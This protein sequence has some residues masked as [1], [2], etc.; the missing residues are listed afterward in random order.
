MGNQRS[1]P[2]PPDFYRLVQLASTVFPMFLQPGE[3]SNV[4]VGH[5]GIRITE[6]H[7]MTRYEEMTRAGEGLWSTCSPWRIHSGDFP[8]FLMRIAQLA[9]NAQIRELVRCCLDG[10][11][12]DHNLLIDLQTNV[13]RYLQ[14]LRRQVDQNVDNKIRV[15]ETMLA[16][17]VELRPVVPVQ[18]MHPPSQ[19]DELPS[20]QDE[21]Q[22]QQDEL[23]SQQD[24]LPS[25][26]A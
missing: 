20:Q 8:W 22:S 3:D 16:I 6:I 18:N 1:Q 25:Q 2:P 7:P 4:V 12:N 24:E 26:P 17:C 5:D 10:R 14:W 15:C 13:N 11:N 9:L 23:P 19:Q 21:L